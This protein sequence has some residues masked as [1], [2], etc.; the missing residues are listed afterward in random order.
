MRQLRAERGI[1]TTIVARLASFRS[2]VVAVGAPP[3]P[4]AARRAHAFEERIHGGMPGGQV[5]ARGW[6]PG[7]LV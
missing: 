7:R 2:A 1:S 3:G 6:A 4:V 5:G